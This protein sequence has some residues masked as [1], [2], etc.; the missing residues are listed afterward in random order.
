MNSLMVNEF[1]DGNDEITCIFPKLENTALEVGSHDKYSTWLCLMLY[2]SLDPTP[3]A[4]FF[5]TSQLNSAL[6]DL[7]CCVGGYL[8]HILSC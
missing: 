2:L 3:C 8:S 5:R 7:L 1:S 4:V 6:N